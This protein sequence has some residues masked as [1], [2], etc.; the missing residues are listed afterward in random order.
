MSLGSPIN[1]D[2]EPCIVQVNSSVV[3]E[4]TDYT[5]R[6]GGMTTSTI[7]DASG[8][9]PVSGYSKERVGDGEYKLRWRNPTDTDFDK[10]IIYRGDV[11]DFPADAGHEIARVNGSPNVDLSYNDH[12][13]PDAG[14]TY[15]YAIRALDHAG[16]SSSLAG[17]G[18]LTVTTVTKTASP[19]SGSGKV[20]ILPNEGT[21]SVLGSDASASSAPES[22]GGLQ[23]SQ[24]TPQGE[25]FIKWILT[26]KKISLG[27]LAILIA[28]GY[29]VF[30]KGNR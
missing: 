5:F 30:K 6:V 9:S 3:G 17:D 23:S 18:S 21:G 24:N 14:K 1:T 10:V 19:V 12:F 8:P 27:V 2:S 7:Y 25:G 13:A 20:T 22:T 28:I 15:F 29:F 16:N 4:Q 11:V 26:H